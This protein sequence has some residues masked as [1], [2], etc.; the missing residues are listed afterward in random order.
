MTAVQQWW[1]DGGAPAEVLFREDFEHGLDNYSNVQGANVASLT[2]SPWNG[3][4]LYLASQN[5]NTAAWFE[6]LL[7]STI[8]FNT[9]EVKFYIEASMSDDA[10]EIFLVS[11]PR[12]V[13]GRQ[14]DDVTQFFFGPYRE[15]AYDGQ[16]R[17]QISFQGE[18]V[19][20]LG[21]T[22]IIGHW[23]KLTLRISPGVFQTTYTIRDLTTG[24]DVFNGVFSNEHTPLSFNKLRFIV[25]SGG[26][27]CP[28][29]YDDLI[30]YNS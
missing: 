19:D 4:G 3:H 17:M 2:A 10:G 28:T 12:G 30:L 23:Y 6:R 26:T 27:T 11:N 15:A 1:F 25:D 9:M 7:D 20:H 18:S 24:N 13:G 22:A 8:T 29:I 16:R 5:S 21:V 14:S